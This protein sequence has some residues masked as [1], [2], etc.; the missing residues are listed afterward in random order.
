[1]G[2]VRSIKGHVH[3]FS[4][5][6]YKDG[7]EEKFII[8]T[9]TTDK[10]ILFTK[11]GKFYTILGDNISKG[12]G[13][14]ESIRL[15]IDMKN[16]DDIVEMMVF[17]PNVKLLVASSSG[18]GF[19]VASEDILSQTRLGKQILLLQ[20]GH[21]AIACIKVSGDKVASIGENRKLLVFGIDEIPEMKK[22]QGVTLQKFTD[23]K[24][25]AIKTFNSLDG[26]SWSHGDRTRLEV[27][28]IP[29]QGRRGSVGKIPPSGFPKNNKF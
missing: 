11:C 18:K 25:T 17:E 5:I 8:H 19:V 15:I 6:K 14:G 9:H 1:M 21:S 3:D 22:G 2:W 29:W 16:E 20:P 27:N 13:H 10:I 4:S 7:D 12:K 26:L 23:A 24:M 28:T